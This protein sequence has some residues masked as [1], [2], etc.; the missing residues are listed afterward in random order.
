MF[1]VLVTAR[2]FSSHTN[3]AYEFLS[4]SGCAV[5]KISPDELPAHF[6]TA[7]GIIAGLE[8]YT[9]E[10]LNQFACLKVISRYG[11]GYDSVDLAAAKARD[12][13]VTFTPGANNDAVADLAIALMLASARSISL[14]HRN[15]KNGKLVRPTGFQMWQ[16]TLGV[17]GTGKI[18]KGVI[19]RAKGF[20]MRI[21]CYDVYPDRKFADAYGAIYCD[22]DTLLR[23]SDFITLHTPLLDSTKHMIDSAAIGK[24]KSSAI[25]VNTARGGLIDEEALYDALLNNRIAAAGLDVTEC[26]PTYSSPLLNLDNCIITPHSGAVTYDAVDAMSMM[27]SRNL[28]EILTTG[29]CANE[30]G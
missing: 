6:A 1:K 20:S 2:S 16:K 19:M 18:G 30:V 3:E 12:I 17:I 27:A 4:N 21:L 15:L 5:K 7:D 13:K 24:M 28:I 9:P 22:M 26:E 10:I 29:K 11:V 23:E 8:S 14:S 25:L